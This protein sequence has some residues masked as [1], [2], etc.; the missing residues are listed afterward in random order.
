MSASARPKAGP[1]KT[2]GRFREYG[3]AQF[4]PDDVAFAAELMLTIALAYVVTEDTSKRPSQRWTLI[5]A[6]HPA[7]ILECCTG[8]LLFAVLGVLILL[9]LILSIAFAQPSNADHMPPAQRAALAEA[10]A[11]RALVADGCY[12]RAVE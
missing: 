11:E 1:S 2:I 5:R 4:D 7:A 6:L 12:G 3:T 9:F 10:A 8:V